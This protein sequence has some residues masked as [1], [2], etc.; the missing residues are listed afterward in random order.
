MSR[1][2]TLLAMLIALLH[3]PI[4]QVYAQCS[5]ATHA[6]QVAQPEDAD[7]GHHGGHHAP[8]PAAPDCDSTVPDDCCQAMAACSLVIDISDAVR[9]ADGS[10]GLFVADAREMARPLSRRAAPEPPPPRA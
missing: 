2:L 9:V 1:V 6:A 3:L 5:H 10:P 4:A 7:A 8:E